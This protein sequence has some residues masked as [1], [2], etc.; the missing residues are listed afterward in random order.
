MTNRF[1]SSASDITRLHAEGGD[2][3]ELNLPA[4]F[5]EALPAAS[6]AAP[7]NA[8]VFGPGDYTFGDFIKIGMP[9]TVVVLIVGVILVPWLPP[10]YGP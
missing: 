3:A 10:L 9:F 2:H 7:V 4:E 5:A 8:L 1:C 6:H